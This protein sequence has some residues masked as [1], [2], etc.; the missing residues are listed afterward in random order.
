MTLFYTS[1]PVSEAISIVSLDNPEYGEV[2]M[3]SLSLRYFMTSLGL[4][5]ANQACKWG[6]EKNIVEF[7]NYGIKLKIFIDNALPKETAVFI[8]DEK[9]PVITVELSG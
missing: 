1:F 6:D 3:N 8:K 7:N 5:T 2:R 4:L 9:S